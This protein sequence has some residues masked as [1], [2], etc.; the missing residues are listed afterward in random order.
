M[1]TQWNIKS[2]NAED[3]SD[4]KDVVTSVQFIVSCIDGD[5]T[6]EAHGNAQFTYQE[7]NPF[8]LFSDLTED[9]VISWVKNSLTSDEIKFYEETA[10]NRLLNVPTN[11]EK[12]LPWV[13]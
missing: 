2:I 11:N 12:S 6:S 8:I 9:E 13:A 5:K 3:I 7:G 4:K 1:K 10:K